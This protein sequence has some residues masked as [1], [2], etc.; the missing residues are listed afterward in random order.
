MRIIFLLYHGFSES[1]G[2]S[3]KILCQIKALRELGHRVNVCT[4]DMNKNRH[5]VRMM[6]EE[7]IEDYGTGKWA[8]V[9]KRISYDG[10]YRYAV[11]Q[12]V[13]MIYVRSFHNANPF[14]VRLFYRLQKAGIKIAME[15]PTYPYKK[16][17]KKRWIDYPLWWKE[18]T[19]M[20]ILHRYVDRI[21]TISK[22]E[23]LFGMPTIP[24]INGINLD[25]IHPIKPVPEDGAIHIVAVAMFCL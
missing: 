24:I 14:T 23:R 1:S 2:I 19:Y 17:L 4:Y 25:T 5:R 16:E 15:I 21:V 9:R 22:D 10:I 7:I 13:N 12:E 20:P 6:D 11:A 18:R 3:K 8:A